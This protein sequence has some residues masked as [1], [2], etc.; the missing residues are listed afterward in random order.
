MFAPPCCRGGQSSANVSTLHNTAAETARAATRFRQRSPPSVIATAVKRS[1]KSD[2]RYAPL[3]MPPASCRCRAWMMDHRVDRW[4]RKVRRSRWACA[5]GRAHC[6]RR[7]SSNSAAHL[8]AI[9]A[10][11]ICRG[12]T[13]K[14]HVRQPQQCKPKAWLSAVRP[15][16]GRNDGASA[17][18]GMA[19]DFL[20]VTRRH[21]STGAPTTDRRRAR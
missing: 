8:R 21:G 13:S 16:G 19:T 12:L 6:F 18:H 7:S 5:A 11:E 4:P 9:H 2:S 15:R 10:R 14:V 20:H 3:T 1:R 17:R